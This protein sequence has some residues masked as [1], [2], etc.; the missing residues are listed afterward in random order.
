MIKYVH[1][2]TMQSWLICYSY[3]RTKIETNLTTKLDKFC[4]TCKFAYLKGPL[5][6]FSPLSLIYCVLANPA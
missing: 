6:Y 3:F 5:V 1:Y 4:Y 2:I